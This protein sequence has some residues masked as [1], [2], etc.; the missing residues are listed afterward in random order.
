[1]SA[2]LE[3][4]RL[5]ALVQRDFTD[6]SIFRHRLTG[7]E[8][9]CTATLVTARGTS[10]I[11]TSPLFCKRKDCPTCAGMVAGKIA[12]RLY[13]E[14]ERTGTLFW[15]GV[16]HGELK[17]LIICLWRRNRSKERFGQRARYL[18]I[19]SIEGMVVVSDLNDRL[20]GQPIPKRNSEIARWVMDIYKP[21]EGVRWSASAGFGIKDEKHTT[22]KHKVAKKDVYIVRQNKESFDEKL[23][24]RGERLEKTER[25]G[26][27]LFTASGETWV[28]IKRLS[29][30]K[31]SK[32]RQ[33]GTT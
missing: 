26:K 13:I 32:T 7:A 6:E 21:V 10:H 3:L 23:I 11:A 4:Q 14:Q 18:A 12:E 9:C 31:K 22:A 20:K 8:L 30:P 28:E 16:C 33:G 15:R 24:E 27:S 5:V 1:M 2:N 29:K 17:A 19:P 25:G